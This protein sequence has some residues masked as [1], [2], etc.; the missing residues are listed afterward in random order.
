LGV[1]PVDTLPPLPAQ[2]SVDNQVDPKSQI[3]RIEV[4]CDKSKGREVL[5]LVELDER[6]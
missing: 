2:R 5:T 1:V 6:S 4:R 3:G